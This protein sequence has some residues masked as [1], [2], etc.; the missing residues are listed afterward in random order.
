MEGRKESTELYR[1]FIYTH[2]LHYPALPPII[3]LEPRTDKLSTVRPSPKQEQKFLIKIIR[4]PPHPVSPDDDTLAN[5]DTIICYTVRTRTIDC[6]FSTQSHV[7]LRLH[8]R[9]TFFLTLHTIGDTYCASTVQCAPSGY[10]MAIEW[11]K[12]KGRRK[13]KAQVNT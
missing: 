12:E 7:T 2:P 1:P 8:S 4:R 13:K 3:H 9:I 11:R 6:R 10:K 5:Y